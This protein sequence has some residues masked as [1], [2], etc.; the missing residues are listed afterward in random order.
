M[1]KPQKIVFIHEEAD[2]A[3]T[4]EML[5]E[6]EK[7]FADILKAKI[8]SPSILVPLKKGQNRPTNRAI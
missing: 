5:K 8:K 2:E 4:P 3:M 7:I 1:K 6:A